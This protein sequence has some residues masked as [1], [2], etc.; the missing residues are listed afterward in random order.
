MRLGDGTEVPRLPGCERWIWDGDF[1]GRINLRFMEGTEALPAFVSGH[2]GYAV[3]PWKRRRGY[4]TEALRLMLPLARA[5][6][7]SGVEITCDADNE[8]S[9]RVIVANGG[10]LLGTGLDWA[11]PT[12]R[13]LVFR[14]PTE[15][16][17]P[18]A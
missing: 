5:E 3:V 13:K 1:C 18:A 15:R 11:E 16:Q 10:V 4:A 6:G 9:R 14:V 12:K 8:A 2:I 17:E 7:L